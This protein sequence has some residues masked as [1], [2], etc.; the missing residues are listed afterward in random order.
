MY[1]FLYKESKD[2]LKSGKTTN[3][4]AHIIQIVFKDMWQTT[5]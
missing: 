4:F 3:L 1:L 5:L 2:I